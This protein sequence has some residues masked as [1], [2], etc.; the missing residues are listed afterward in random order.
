[1]KTVDYTDEYLP[2]TP[3]LFIC[4]CSFEVLWSQS[5]SGENNT[6]LIVLRENAK[7]MLLG[8]KKIEMTVWAWLTTHMNWAAFTS[9]WDDFKA[10]QFHSK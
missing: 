9:E 3:V 1:M 2:H 8:I 7:K 4:K 5:A 10:S 6:I